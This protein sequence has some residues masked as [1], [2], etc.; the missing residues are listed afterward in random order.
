MTRARETILQE[1]ACEEERLAELERAR[2][3][4][5][6]RRESLQSELDGAMTPTPALLQLPLGRRLR[7]LTV[8]R[9]YESSPSVILF[10]P[11]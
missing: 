9:R 1:I 4:A 5:Q 6:P 8:G 2:E 11:L 7:R 3:E 10:H